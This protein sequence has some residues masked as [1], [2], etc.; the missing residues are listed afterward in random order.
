MEKLP[1]PYNF[2]S[3]GNKEEI[4]RG[5]ISKEDFS[6]KI[7]CSLKN[8]TPL[9]IGGNKNTEHTLTEELGENDYKVTK[10]V[11]PASTI[12]GELRNIIEVLTR[13][14]IK[15]IENERLTYRYQM[16]NKRKNIFGIIKSLPNGEN[17]GY[18]EGAD[19]IR[20]ERNLAKKIS[21]KLKKINENKSSGN[22]EGFY[23]IYINEKNAENYKCNSYPYKKKIDNDSDLSILTKEV[24]GCMKRAIL[25]IATEF[26]RIIKGIKQ[27]N[28]AKIL[29]PNSEIYKFSKN[30]YEDLKILIKERNDSAKPLYI[31]EI[32]E[33]NGV[34]FEKVN[35]EKNVQNSLESLK[36]GDTIIFEP[37]N[38]NAINLAFSEIPRLRYKYSPLDLV[39][40][41]F[42]PC[43][44]IDE[45]CFACRLF[46]TIG[47]NSK[48]NENV[49]EENLNK[50]V[51]KDSF[52][53][54]SRIFITD[55]LSIDSKDDKKEM[56]LDRLNSLGE[57]HPT[58]FN[59]YLKVGDY[60]DN[61]E[62]KKYEIRGRKFYWHHSNKINVGK[63]WEKYKN[64]IKAKENNN[65]NFKIYF[66][67]PLQEFEFEINFKDLN[68]IE[69]G[70]LLYSLELEE[71]ESLH[72]LGKAKAYGFGSCEIKIEECLLEDKKNK[73]TSFSNSYQAIKREEIKKYIDTAKKEYS[74]E[75]DEREEIK[76]L[77]YILNRENTLNFPND[78][79]PFPEST[80]NGKINTLN[81][82][83]DKKNKKKILPTILEYKEKE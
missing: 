29:V 69:L 12:K 47:D 48:N 26:P 54:A 33:D 53:I 38:K 72:K 67:K 8:L 18:I 1:Y 13:S 36:K 17:E 11:I 60:N 82:F 46:G 66:L 42:H 32:K 22:S 16:S 77:K 25:W 79:S 75:N 81:W 3:L 45:L 61:Y 57:P 41:K 49:S 4:E 59:F 78:E 65:T 23:E 20:I 7:K 44:K 34:I 39:P 50:E 62:N 52:S 30:E 35:K 9:F 2:V 70:I 5:K 31:S 74:L 40:K 51:Q 24:A 63:D 37:Q 14:C 10:Y 28:Y 68:K 55:A 6:G 43:N 71:G 76:E 80:K 58:L 21:Q 56:E 83:T 27:P 19:V 15:N 64:S 73:Y